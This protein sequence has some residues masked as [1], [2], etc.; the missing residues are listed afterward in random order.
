MTQTEI[1]LLCAIVAGF[2]LLALS[3][4]AFA[5]H[6]AR[7]GAVLLVVAAVATLLAY[8]LLGDVSR[9]REDATREAIETKYGV[10]VTEWGSP[11]GDSAVWV[12]DG[13]YKDCE[14]DL[15]DRDDPVVTCV[16][17]PAPVE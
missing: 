1:L 12:I 9:D 2:V 13:K 7:V 8:P 15:S 3:V 16:D 6:R 14:L 4:T 10:D 11:L 17:A 5:L